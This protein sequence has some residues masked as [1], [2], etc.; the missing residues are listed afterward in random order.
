MSHSRAKKPLLL[1]TISPRRSSTAVRH[2]LDKSVAP[3]SLWAQAVVAPR[4]PMV[5]SFFA[6][7]AR[8]TS[9]HAAAPPRSVKNARQV[10]LDIGLPP[11][12]SGGKRGAPRLQG[13]IDTPP[14]ARLTLAKPSSRHPEPAKKKPRPEERGAKRAP[15]GRGSVWQV[16]TQ[17]NGAAL[18][19]S[20]GPS[21]E[22]VISTDGVLAM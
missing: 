19:R 1:G 20:C 22:N 17:S 16:T 14:C 6:C 12:R 10:M 2:Y 9:G 18:M 7:C 21:D 8:T 4:N 5:G 13:Q 11:S 15:P 3:F